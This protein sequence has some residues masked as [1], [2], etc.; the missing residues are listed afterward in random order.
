MKLLKK[1]FFGLLI[2]LALFLLVGCLLPGSYRLER[3]VVINA[4]PIKVFGIVADLKTWEDWTTWNL[5]MDPGMKRTFEGPTNGIVAGMSWEGSKVGQGEMKLTKIT[6]PKF[7]SYDLSF[8][9]GKYTSVGEFQF[10]PAG[11]GTKATWSDAGNLGD[12]PIS[13]WAGLFMDKI[14]GPDFEKGLAGLKT[15]A[16]K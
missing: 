15:L 6:A 2:L 8:D 7:L 11:A 9:H 13:R 1:L 16:E 4:P 3:S 12:N 10:E 5:K 14:I